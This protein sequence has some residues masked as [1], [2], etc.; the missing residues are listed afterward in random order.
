[1]IALSSSLIRLE[2]VSLYRFRRRFFSAM[3]AL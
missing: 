1:M 3:A 2:S